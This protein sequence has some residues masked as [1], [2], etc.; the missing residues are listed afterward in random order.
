MKNKI[1][2][3][4]IVPFFLYA[5]TPWH[6]VSFGILNNAGSATFHNEKI[7]WGFEV[8]KLSFVAS[9]IDEEYGYNYCGDWDDDGCDVAKSSSMSAWLLSPRI[10]KRVNLK[11]SN[12]LSSYVDVECYMSFPIVNIKI[13]TSDDDVSASDVSTAENTIDDLLDFMGFKV[14]Y[15][16]QYEI[17][18]QVSLSTSVGYNHIIADFAEDSV[19]LESTMGSTFTKFEINYSF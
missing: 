8:D 13:D 12:K 2:L 14:S 19:K 18:E 4:I 7:F 17:N 9:W 5:D 11:A 3:L 1:W 6:T 15:G 10:G 16:F